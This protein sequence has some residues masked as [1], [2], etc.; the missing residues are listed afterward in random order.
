MKNS[1]RHF[2]QQAGMAGAGILVSKM[3]YRCVFVK[4]LTH[5]AHPAIEKYSADWFCPGK[6]CAGS[7]FC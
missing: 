4:G 3:G 2:L 7:L 6:R 5:Q 1:R